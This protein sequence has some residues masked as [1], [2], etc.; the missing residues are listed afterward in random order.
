MRR[1]PL[2]LL[3]LGTLAL[4]SGCGSSHPT[5]PSGGSARALGTGTGST[6]PGAKLT[7]IKAPN[8]ASPPAGAPVQSGVVQIAY[9]NVTIRPDAIRVKVGT[10]IRWTNFDPIVHNVTSRGGPASF[11]SG[12]LV[13]GSS[14]QVVL[15]HP[16]VVHYLCTIHPVTMN[17]TIEVV[18]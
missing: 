2:L 9:R 1:A 11:S 15:K 17:G 8:Y 7:L 12:S 16:G 6:S 18:S 4:A 3:S 10:T 5:S 13:K 14:F